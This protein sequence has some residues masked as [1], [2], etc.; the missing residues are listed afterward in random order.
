MSLQG[1]ITKVMHSSKLGHGN[2]HVSMSDTEYVT[3]SGKVLEVLRNLTFISTR[4]G[5][6]TF[7]EWKFVYLGSI[8]LLSSSPIKASMFVEKY[9]PGKSHRL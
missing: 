7:D 8:D 1:I 6:S 4:V 2:H 9:V 5:Y 3:I